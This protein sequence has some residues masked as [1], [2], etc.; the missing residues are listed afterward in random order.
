MEPVPRR[1]R[2]LGSPTS[3]LSAAS[4]GRLSP[5]AAA[6]ARL[7]HDLRRCA[8]RNLV[9]AGVPEQVCMTLSGHKTRSVFDRYNVTSGADQIEAVRKLAAMQGA[10]RPE[11]RK[12]VGI[13]EGRSGRT[14]TEPAQTGRHPRFTQAQLTA[15]QWQS[16]ASPTFEN[17][18][19]VAYWLRTID[20]LR[21]AIAGRA[22]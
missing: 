6:A 17:S 15:A 4:C 20:A 16:M 2:P 19:R 7:F 8:V 22:S 1:G 3:G 14:G 18:N 5:S 13:E 9:R 12:V 21:G 10:S 11:G